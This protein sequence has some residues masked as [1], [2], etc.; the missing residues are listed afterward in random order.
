MCYQKPKT[1]KAVCLKLRHVKNTASVLR[2]NSELQRL[3]HGAFPVMSS[4][5]RLYPFCA[6]INFSFSYFWFHHHFV[7]HFE[8]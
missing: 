5:M 2:L 4:Q 6:E 1:D 8:L 3:A 7:I